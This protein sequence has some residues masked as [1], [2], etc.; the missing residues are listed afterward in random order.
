[1]AEYRVDPRR[2][3]VF[4]Q[5]GGGAMA[6][7]LSLGGRDLF[8][9]VATAA[10]A[11]PRTANPPDAEPS[12]RLAVFAYLPNDSSR[13]AQTN[14]GL[15]KLSDAGYPVTAVAIANSSDRLSEDERQ[16]LAR[17][18]DCLDRF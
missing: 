11:L 14:L 4:G 18:I 8:S 5:E 2:V 12:S 15:K 3:V 16:Q 7:L 17:W 6:Y 9:G 10:A 1:M 13:L